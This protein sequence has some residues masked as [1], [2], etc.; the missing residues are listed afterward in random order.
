MLF[1]RNKTIRQVCGVLETANWLFIKLLL[2]RRSAA[3]L[4]PGVVFRNYLNLVGKERWVSRTVFDLFPQAAALQVRLEHLPGKGIAT[5]VGELAQLALLTKAVA[6]RTVFEIGTFRGRTALNFA[7]NS[8]DDC[9]I[10]TLDLPPTDRSTDVAGAMNLADRAIAASS[11]T[12]CDYRGKEGEQKI[13]QLYGNSVEFDFSPYFGQ[14][15]IVF[16]DGAHH[17]DAVVS[18]TKNALRMARPGGFIVWHDF[19]NYGDYNDVTRA[20]L[21]LLPGDQIVQLEETQLAVY[22]VPVG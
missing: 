21:D 14:C 17:Y 19:A 4:F 1:I 9:V 6:P 18:D 20:I 3:G 10:Y 22:R 11:L 7:L 2:K 13:R 15:D 5:P 16:V 12:G 8:S